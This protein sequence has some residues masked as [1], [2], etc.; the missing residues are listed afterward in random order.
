MNKKIFMILLSF[1][2]FLFA[3]AQE[4]DEDFPLKAQRLLS[5]FYAKT[6]PLKIHVFFNQPQ[7]VPGDTVF[8]SVSL[9]AASSYTPIKGRQIVNV[10]LSERNGN[11]KVKHNVLIHDGHG[12]N[13]FI[14]PLDLESGT[15]VV[16]AYSEWMRN[17]DQS[18]FHHS[19][20]T[21]GGDFL[22][23]PKRDSTKFYVEGGKLI[24]GTRNKIIAKGPP[25]VVV[26]RTNNNT[27]ITSCQIGPDGMG[28]FYMT[29][30][31]GT[32][33][34][35]QATNGQFSQLADVEPEGVSMIV[36]PGD[37]K[38][39]CNISLERSRN[40][41]SPI[42]LLLTS[43]DRVV[44]AAKV[45][46]KEKP[47]ALVSISSDKLP[48]G[49]ILATLFDDQGNELSARMF[50]EKKR[51][52]I[53]ANVV[54]DK[55]QYTTREKVRLKVQLRDDF[56]KPVKGKFAITVVGATSLPTRLR[57]VS[58]RSEIEDGIPFGGLDAN[59]INTL[60]DF[61]FNNYLITKCWKRFNWKKILNSEFGT[62]FS[63]QK[64]I[65]LSG[66]ADIRI[67]PD[68]VKVSFF[69]QRNVIIFQSYLDSLGQFNFPVAIDFEN[70]DRASYCVEQR[71]QKLPYVELTNFM[72]PPINFNLGEEND[73]RERNVYAH[74]TTTKRSIDRAYFF[75]RRN[76]VTPT[77]IAKP[78][79]LIEDEVFDA[80]WVIQ[81]NDYLLLPTM[82]ETLREIVPKVQHRK[83]RNK[84]EVRVFIDDLDK[85]G[86]GPPFYF[87]DGVMTDNTE[88]FLSLKPEQVSVI[89]VICTSTK[90]R[91]FGA[92]GRNGVILVETK[93]P[94]NSKNVPVYSNSFL[95]NGINKQI[96]FRAVDESDLQHPRLPLIKH[97]LYWNPMVETDENGF[98]EVSFYT[99]DNTGIFNIKACG[100]SETGEVI[101]LQQQFSVAF[102]KNN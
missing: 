80:D 25:S 4:N 12:S 32:S 91:T 59:Y 20:L 95:V 82:E 79:A 46:L 77:S 48:E 35:A 47:T 71:G 85:T 29:P 96:P 100:V 16:T 102:K 39:P 76:G 7:Y 18:L 55:Q 34:K 73:T 72:I 84:S 67:P 21:V 19:T 58:D 30:E 65:H 1:K 10:I 68:S 89:K 14:L 24:S 75:G 53:A 92:F 88:Y 27:E 40:F 61:S 99:A 44:F 78:H 11:V 9:L 33:Y 101:K 86:D 31:Y 2:I 43:G 5:E 69:L 36:T 83:I 42:S 3:A 37:G 98:A 90:L 23:Y 15:Y 62:S 41:G 74:F 87:I 94:D 56:G 28:V 13:Q 64:F 66:K 93:I 26:I 8:Y 81:L 52:V 97:C 70:E 54:L 49:L 51:S 60:D 38:R 63:A 6:V 22:S 17:H 57:E 50:I 45:S